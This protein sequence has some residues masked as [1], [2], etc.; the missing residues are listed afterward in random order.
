MDDAV[1]AKIH[2]KAS[3][4]AAN[5][6]DMRRLAHSIRGGHEVEPVVLGMMAGRMY[7]SFYYQ[8]RRVLGRDPT[9]EEFEEFLGIV[10][11]VFSAGGDDDSDDD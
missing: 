6:S 5:A 4:C 2:Q 10:R 8:T 9:S 7:N 3:E 1:L 11:G